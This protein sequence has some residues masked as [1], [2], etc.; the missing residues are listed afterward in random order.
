MKTEVSANFLGCIEQS[1]LL[2][3]FIVL[4]Q[5]QNDQK[6]YDV[7]AA[8]VQ[9]PTDSRYIVDHAHTERETQTSLTSL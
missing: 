6:T 5:E 9:S 1:L 4:A 7:V 2:R 3:N 8:A